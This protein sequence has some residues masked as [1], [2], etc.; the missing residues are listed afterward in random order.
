MDSE[1]W[2]LRKRNENKFSV[3][4]KKI[5]RWIYGPLKSNVTEEWKRKKNSDLETL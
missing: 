1:T 3:F 2:S 5:L 4:E